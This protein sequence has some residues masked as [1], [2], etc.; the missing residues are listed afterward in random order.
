M[1]FNP[2]TIPEALAVEQLKPVEK[3]FSKYRIKIQNIIVNNVI[4]GDCLE[5]LTMRVSWQKSTWKIFDASLPVSLSS[6]CPWYPMNYKV[7]PI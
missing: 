5:F 6:K 3:E 1:D 4:E 2:V 7:P